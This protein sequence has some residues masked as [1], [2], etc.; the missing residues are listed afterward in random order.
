MS[1]P[2]WYP[3]TSGSRGRAT[4]AVAELG[5][6]EA[7]GRDAVAHRDA[8]GARK[9]PEVGVEGPVLLHDHDDVAD[10]VDAVRPNPGSDAC[11][12]GQQDQQSRD[13]WK[14]THVHMQ[15]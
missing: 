2:S 5:V 7:R 6:G 4:D 3:T 15:F 13:K 8:V 10:R 12:G 14:A 11:A 9:R 1:R